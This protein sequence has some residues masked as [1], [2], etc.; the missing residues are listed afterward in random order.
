MTQTSKTQSRLPAI[1]PT[2]LQD[3]VKALTEANIG[4]SNRLTTAASVS[5]RRLILR[6][7][8]SGRTEEQ[9]A[10][11]FKM[12]PDAI[13]REIA[14][15]YSLLT[16]YFTAP[17]P[18]HTYVRYAAFQFEIIRKAQ[19]AYDQIMNP[20]DIE[21]ITIDSVTG[22]DIITLTPQP[23]GGR[24]TTAAISALRLQSDTMD[25][26]I[27]K[28]IQFNVIQQNVPDEIAA[29]LR[30]SSGDLKIELRSEIHTLTLLLDEVDDEQVLVYRTNQRHNDQG[31]RIIRK[32]LIDSNGIIQ[33]ANDW[34]KKTNFY[35]EQ[36]QKLPKSKL[37]IDQIEL[38]QNNKDLV[39]L[40]LIAN[41]TQRIINTDTLPGQSMDTYEH[42]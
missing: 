13:E 36:G 31:Y 11:M 9:L 14:Q 8:A 39:E 16:H 30:M 28:G 25:K 22:K 12:K 21:T 42:H 3:D 29:L 19:Q 5:R 17:K 15:A 33:F 6:E 27:E 7:Y 2:Q 37:T 24:Q 4:R 41:Q 40:E 35:D 32:P 20:P 10:I 38:L 34:K 23:A 26:I 18:H 1:I